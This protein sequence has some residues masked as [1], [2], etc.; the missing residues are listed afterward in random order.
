MSSTSPTAVL[1]LN[2]GKRPMISAGAMSPELLHRFEHHARGYLQNKEGLEAKGYVDHIVYSFEDPLFSDWYQSQQD[3]LSILSFTDFMAKVRARWLPKRWQQDLARKVRSTKQNKTAFSDFIDSLR[4]DNLLLKGSQF[5][6]SP[7]QLRTQIE[8][9]ISPKLAASFDRWKDNHE[10]SE[11]ESEKENDAPIDPVASAAANLLKSASSALKAEAKLQSFVDTLTKLDQKLVEDRNAQKRDAEDAARSLKRSGSSVGLSDVSRRAP[12]TR[13]GSTSN[14]RTQTPSSSSSSSRPPKL[15][16]RERKY[17]EMYNGCKKCRGFYLPDNHSCNFPTGDGYVERSM[18]T[19][20]D[21]RKRIKLPALP[22][23][24]EEMG[25]SINSI[26]GSFPPQPSTV[27]P[28]LPVASV[29]GMSS[30][31]ITSV[32]PPNDNSVLAAGDSDLSCDSNDSVRTHIP[33]ILPHLL[34]E[35]A[36]DSHDPSSLSRV[37][38]SA[39]IDHGSPPVLIDQTLVNRLHLPT[40]LLP[41]PFPV[42]G[43]F[44]SNGDG[45]LHVSL[46]HWVKLKLHD[47]NNWYSAHTVRAIVAPNLCHEII[48]GLPFL[49]HNRIIVNAHERT[50]IDSNCMFDLLHPTA[51]VI[52][53]PV[54]KLCDLFAKVKGYC[55]LLLDELKNIC[56]I[57]RPLIDARCEHVNGI[58][59]VAAI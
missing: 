29:L 58:D 55:K 56:T 7:S 1:S 2:N 30:Y 17:L 42:S 16:D 33:F 46:T 34:W 52:C 6:L 18:V 54:M 13:N 22:V 57:R 20:N 25:M 24:R 14:T 37:P 11:D 59:I 36:V 39:L 47:R 26:S 4:R 49:S 15:T 53:K 35:C 28:P 38:V 19:V 48:L 23:P 3:L 32:Y 10:S 45:S 9:N 5:H 21:A 12:Y 27:P 8:L 50:A 44:F 43:A 40:R 41:C 51:P 31:P